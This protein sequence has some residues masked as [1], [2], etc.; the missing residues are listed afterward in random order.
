MGRTRQ[1]PYDGT[2]K[3]FAIGIKPMPV[4][5]WIDVDP[6][7]P[8][9]LAEKRRLFATRLND[10]FVARADTPA[11]QRE[12]LD[13]LAEHLPQRFP[14]LYR[15]EGNWLHV[16]PDGTAADLGAIGAPPLLVAAELVA[17]DLVLMRRDSAGWRLVAAAVCFPSSWTLREKFG[18]PMDEIHAPVPGFGAGSRPAE[19]ITRMFDNLRPDMPVVR[20]NWSLYG[21]D[22]LHHPPADEPAPPRF[23]TGARAEPVFL[24][25]ERQ[26]LRRLPLS[27]DIVFTI[28]IYLDPL[29]SLAR[30]PDGAAVARSLLAQLQELDGPQLAYKGIAADRSRLLERLAELARPEPG[31]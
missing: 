20:W 27:G 21:D 2:S 3:L 30:D 25:V 17:E 16:I 8:D 24:R 1:T 9:Y 15:R 23:G 18:R 5:S 7:L 14:D 4:E 29:G 12:V 22:Q 31:S 11:A 26:T 13:L 19:L 10:V 6:L 28:R